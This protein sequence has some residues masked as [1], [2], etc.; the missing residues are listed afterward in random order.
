MNGRPSCSSKTHSRHFFV[1]YVIQPRQMRETFVPVEPRLVYCMAVFSTVH[2]NREPLTENVHAAS[3]DQSPNLAAARSLAFAASSSRFLGVA[4]VS[5]EA[6]R[7]SQIPE[8][9][10]IAL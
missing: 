2:V 8:M 6:S 4:V 3:R 10:S 9:S 5:S 1:P 7:R